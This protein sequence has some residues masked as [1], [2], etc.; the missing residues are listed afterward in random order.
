[1]NNIPN[2]DMEKLTREI[3]IILCGTRWDV[4]KDI[5]FNQIKKIKEKEDSKGDTIYKFYYYGEDSAK[6]FIN[7][8]KE[9][10][11]ESSGTFELVPVL[12][13]WYNGRTESGR[14]RDER[15][16]G[17]SNYLL[18]F[19][20]TAAENKTSPHHWIIETARGHKLIVREITC[21]DVSNSS[22]SD[23]KLTPGLTLSLTPTTP[24][25]NEQ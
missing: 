12:K 4:P 6:P 1:M 20:K 13:N 21:P 24:N 3:G 15:I 14:R 23:K 8:A 7:R 17:T 16:C 25:K 10:I 2:K 19:S 18:S 11:E 5:F 22:S 9:W